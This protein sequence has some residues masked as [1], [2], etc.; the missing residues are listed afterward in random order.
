MAIALAGLIN[1]NS[2]SNTFPG[3]I[4]TALFKPATG[5]WSRFLAIIEP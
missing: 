3:T 4:T 1:T 5:E 2:S